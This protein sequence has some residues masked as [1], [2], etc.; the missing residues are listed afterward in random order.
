MGRA[1][2]E[3]VA[4]FRESEERKLEEERRETERRL[5]AQRQGL[6]GI[7]LAP[8]EDQLLRPGQADAAR[9]RVRDMAR[10]LRV[11]SRG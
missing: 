11:G 4:A 1:T 9:Q 7:D 5:T 3:H 8:R 6:V 10:N 2:A